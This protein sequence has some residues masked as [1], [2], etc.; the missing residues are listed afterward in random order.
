MAE[1]NKLLTIL[2]GIAIILILIYTTQNT[3]QPVQ[4]NDCTRLIH[5]F[6][7]YV[8]RSR[9]PIPDNPDSLCHGLY[10]GSDYSSMEP[11]WAVARLVNVSSEFHYSLT[12]AG[13]EET[14]AIVIPM[15]EDEV[16]EYAV[17]NY[18]RIDMNN[19]C[20][21]FFMMADSRYP[22]EI[23]STFI[24]PEEIECD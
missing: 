2:G 18:Y 12:F 11:R 22:S 14:A 20:R 8:Q 13:A 7:T 21:F 19:I 3:K 24:K 17:G 6:D 5:D 23:A 9:L 15:K 16:K 10:V 4:K 1:K